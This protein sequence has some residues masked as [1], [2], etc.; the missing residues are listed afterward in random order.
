MNNVTY[1]KSEYLEIIHQ[2]NR[3]IVYPPHNHVSIY[4]IGLVIEGHVILR[5]N[6]EPAAFGA[7]HFFIVKPYQ[8]HALTLPENYEMI[9]L[10]IQRKCIAE[11]N[12]EDLYEMIIKR[13]PQTSASHDRISV[14]LKA[15]LN[16]LFRL[17][18]FTPPGKIMYSSAYNLRDNPEKNIS[19]QA[20]ADKAYISKYHYIKCFKREI[21]MPPH[22]FQI[23]N[24]IRKAQRLIENGEPLTAV[25]VS[26]GFYDQSHFTRYFKNLVGLTPLEYQQSCM[27]LDDPS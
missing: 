12:P 13:L 14:L 9:S 27:K 26:L 8:M 17:D 25:A 22:K 16:N 10:C 6:N 24:R 15:A 21:G 20:M 5:C 4:T 11:Q 23:Q 3:P 1:Y 7:N 2:K 19:L 18:R